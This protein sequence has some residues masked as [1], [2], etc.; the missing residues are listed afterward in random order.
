MSI[1][2]ARLQDVPAAESRIPGALERVIAAGITWNAVRHHTFGALRV[3]HFGAYP[4]AEDNGV[5]AVST[6]IVNVDAGVTLYRGLRLQAT[7]LNVLD[8]RASDIQYLYAS[9]LRG[10]ATGVSDVHVHPIEPGQL[11][12]SLTFPP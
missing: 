3:R 4:L 9:R 2:R 6:T 10:E 7:I 1:A 11:R 8:S 5:R 12:V